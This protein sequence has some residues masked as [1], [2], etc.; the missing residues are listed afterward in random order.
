MLEIVKNLYRFSESKPHQ[1]ALVF[2]EEKF[3]YREF[4][5]VIDERTN[6]LTDIQKN[7]RVGLLSDH[8]INNLINYFAIHNLGGLPC[9]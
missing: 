6:L 8:P 3:T 2:D 7:E 9:F 1:L 5:Q 4:I